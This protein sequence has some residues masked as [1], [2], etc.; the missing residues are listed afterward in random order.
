MTDE[1]IISPRGTTPIGLPYPEDTDAVAAGAQA[2]KALAQ[3]VETKIIGGSPQSVY[4]ALRN[5]GG[6]NVP[7]AWTYDP[8]MGGVIGSGANYTPTN[9]RLQMVAVTVP[10]AYT[11]TGVAVTVDTIGSGFPG[12]VYNGFGLWQMAANG[13]ATFLRDTGP[14]NGIHWTTAGWAPRTWASPIQLAAGVVYLVGFTMQ[15][16]NTA[17]VIRGLGGSQANAG[18]P[19]PYWRSSAVTAPGST[20]AAVM[21]TWPAAS[22]IADNRVPLLVIY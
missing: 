5:L 17:P 12:T 19:S 15:T 20:Q 18:I 2:I 4:E 10:H 21:K 11:S 13:D 16:T 7:I 22:L 6:A 3:A 9:N 8:V 14:S 1:A